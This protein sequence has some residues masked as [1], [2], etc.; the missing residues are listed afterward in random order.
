MSGGISEDP[1]SGG[2][3]RL[4]HGRNT[5]GVTVAMSTTML[6]TDFLSEKICKD[7][8]RRREERYERSSPVR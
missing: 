7:Y 5:N 8:V 2:G 1:Q 4:G 6:M 3:S